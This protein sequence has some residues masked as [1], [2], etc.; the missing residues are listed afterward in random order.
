MH[1]TG[2]AVSHQR[3]SKRMGT[4][5]ILPRVTRC[6]GSESAEIGLEGAFRG[7]IEVALLS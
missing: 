7:G 5:E 2:E 1:A 4:D 6:Q 3:G